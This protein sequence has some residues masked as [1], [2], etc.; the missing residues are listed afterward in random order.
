MSLLYHQKPLKNGKNFLRLRSKANS[1]DKIEYTTGEC[2]VLAA[3]LHQKMRWPI[4]VACEAGQV[5]WRDEAD[6]DIS[7]PLVSHVYAISPDGLAWDIRGAVALKDVVKDMKFNFGAEVDTY[8]CE[9]ESDFFAYVDNMGKRFK[10]LNRPL[11]AYTQEDIEL[12]WE[13]AEIVFKGLDIF[14]SAKPKP[15]RKS[16][17]RR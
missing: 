8:L 9:R 7:T 2:H 4:L 15:K 5:F 17:M 1:T 10:H 12:A 14:E 3:A 6:H 13:V 16:S 11:S